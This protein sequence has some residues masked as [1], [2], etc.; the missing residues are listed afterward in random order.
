MC[1][2]P[3]STPF[4]V[5]QL[6]GLPAPHF[7]LI[8]SFLHSPPSRAG[9]WAPR[10][11][12]NA[13]YFQDLNPYASIAPMSALAVEVWTTTAGILFDNFMVATDYK[14][15]FDF[16]QSTTAKKAKTE[17]EAIKKEEREAEHQVGI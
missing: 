16:A 11:I 9:A 2:F 8:R 15:A 4:F 17:R 3:L 10:R 13:A 14:V 1:T 5:L 6:H 12:K 7:V